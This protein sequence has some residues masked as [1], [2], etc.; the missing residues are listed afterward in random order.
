MGLRDHL[1]E[2]LKQKGS[3]ELYVQLVYLQP[4]RT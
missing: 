4:A 2:A 3:G 1:D